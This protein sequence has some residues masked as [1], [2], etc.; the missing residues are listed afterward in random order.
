M[1]AVVRR[2][3]RKEMLLVLSSAKLTAVIKTKQI[4]N[5]IKKKTCGKKH[6]VVEIKRESVLLT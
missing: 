5:K 6:R 4:K 3:R 2:Q 1:L